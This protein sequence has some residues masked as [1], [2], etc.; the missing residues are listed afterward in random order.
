M[1]KIFKL[2]LF[3]TFL[4]C[5]DKDDTPTPTPASQ[6]PPPTQTGSNTVG[7]LLDGAV[8]K[9]DNLPNSTNCFYQYVKGQ[10][11]F[12]LAFRKTDKKNNFLGIDVGTNA[13]EIVQGETYDLFEFLPNKASA[14]YIF[15]LTQ[16]FTDNIHT[17]KLK[18]TKLDKINFIVSGTFW[19][20]VID[21]NGV[22]H[23]IREGRFDMHYTN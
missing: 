5:C 19:F 3:T 15:N 13:K 11:Y 18:I 17:G 2:I 16:N 23:S 9:P 8:F 6:L 12:T 7:C 4:A 20:D 14:T 1:K 22:V 10:Y 21:S